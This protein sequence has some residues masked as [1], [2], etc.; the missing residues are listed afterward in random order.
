ML[1]PVIQA[2]RPPELSRTCLALLRGQWQLRARHDTRA[3]DWMES[4]VFFGGNTP[5]QSAAG[6][7]LERR[8]PQ[9][10]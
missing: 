2:A 4:C 7:N 9:A 6:S 10:N 5:C 3:F 8:G 1:T